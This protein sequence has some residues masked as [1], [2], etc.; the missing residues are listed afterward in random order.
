MSS[1]ATTGKVATFRIDRVCFFLYRKKTQKNKKYRNNRKQV[2]YRSYI[3][4]LTFLMV[5]GG[6]F[7]RGFTGGRACERVLGLTFDFTPC[8]KDNTLRCQINGG[9]KSLKILINGG[10][11]GIF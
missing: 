9:G 2:R 4:F 5:G 11:V 3:H 10:W 1:A 7:D 6:D 8:K